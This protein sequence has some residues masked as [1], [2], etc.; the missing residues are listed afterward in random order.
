MQLPVI[1]TSF[2]TCSYVIYLKLICSFLGMNAACAESWSTW[3]TFAAAL[4]LGLLSWLWACIFISVLLASDLSEIFLYSRSFHIWLTHLPSHSFIIWRI[5]DSA[6]KLLFLKS[7]SANFSYKR[8]NSKY[9]Q[10]CMPESLCH[11]YSTLTLP[12]KC[13]HRPYLSKWAWLCSKKLCRNRQQ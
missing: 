1:I 10:F 11:H 3:S 5:H 4:I 9:F 2:Y 13:R 6:V 7:G 8:S 12:C